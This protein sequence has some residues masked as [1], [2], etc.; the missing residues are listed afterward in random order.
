MPSGI[1]IDNRLEQ[2]SKASDPIHATPSGISM[3]VRPK[4]P[5]K[6]YVHKLI[7]SSGTT[8]L[9]HPRISELEEDSII[10][11]QLSRES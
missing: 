9:E 5:E 11:L 2:P 6:A 10:A 4:Q 3:V 1:V 8:V 7:T